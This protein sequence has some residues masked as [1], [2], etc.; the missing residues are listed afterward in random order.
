MKSYLVPWFYYTDPLLISS[1]ADHPAFCTEFSAE[2]ET[3]INTVLCAVQTLVK[4]CERDEQREQHGDVKGGE[5]DA[6]KASSAL[7]SL[8]C[9]PA[10]QT[11]NQVLV[12]SNVES[13]ITLLQL[14]L[15][16]IQLSSDFRTSL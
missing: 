2:L 8:L 6:F 10:L 13:S 3:N 5:N 16:L 14:L 11:L 12:H 4:R 1:I 7:C 9:T 15:Y